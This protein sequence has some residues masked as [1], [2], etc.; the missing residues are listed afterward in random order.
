MIQVLLTIFIFRL[1]DNGLSIAK[2]IYLQRERY[3]LSSLLNAGSTFF[4]LVVMVNVINDNSPAS[5]LVMCFATFLGTLLPA[6][7]VDKIEKDKLFVYE[8]TTDTFDKGI[9]FADLVRNNNIPVKTMIAYDS[10]LQKVLHCKVYCQSKA[11]S[12]MIKDI[13]PEEFK[14]HAYVAKEY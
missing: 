1:L 2:T 5:I 10:D 6:K 14:Y 7:I 9:E 12:V 3:L 13:L 11:E 8:I 4:Y